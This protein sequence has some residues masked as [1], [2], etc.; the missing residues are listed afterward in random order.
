MAQFIG[1]WHDGPHRKLAKFI[2]EFLSF[3]LDEQQILDRITNRETLGLSTT[4][5]EH[6]LTAVR[7]K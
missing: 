3:T 5:E 1:I 7:G 2:D 4:E 6:A